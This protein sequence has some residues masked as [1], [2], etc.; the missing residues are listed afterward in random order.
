VYV[1]DTFNSRIRKITPQGQVT[2]LAGDGMENSNNGNGTAASFDHCQGIIWNN[3]GYLYVADTQNSLI[4]KI[5]S[6]ADVTTLAGSGTIGSNDGTGTAASFGQPTSIITDKNG[7]I[8][9][10]DVD[11]NIVRKITPDKVVTKYA[12]G[13]SADFKHA[14]GIAIDNSGNLYVSDFSNRVI[15]KIDINKN[16]VIF[17]GNKDAVQALNGPALKAGFMGPRGIAVNSKG[18]IYVADAGS[19]QILKVVLE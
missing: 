15:Y 2:T 4:R 3:S 9:V 8:Y 16:V 11:Y 10:T 13:G 5:S 12:D 7:N 6:T 18:D 17:A 19:H 14:Q 1:A